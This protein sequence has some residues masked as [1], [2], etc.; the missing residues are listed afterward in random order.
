MMRRLSS[1]N[2]F[3]LDIIRIVAAW[4]VL[5]GHGFS[6][7]HITLLKDQNYFFNIQN[8]GVV[9]LFML[10]GF[11][12]AYSLNVKNKDHRYTIKEYVKQRVVRIYSGYLPALLFIC[13]LDGISF[14]NFRNKYYFAEGFSFRNFLINLF[15]L[16]STP[17]AFIRDGGLFGSGRPLWTLSTEWWIYMSFGTLFLIIANSLKIT[18]KR[19]ILL[20]IFLVTPFANLAGKPDL[21]LLFLLGALVYYIYDK[22]DLK[23]MSILVVLNVIAIAAYGLIFKEAYDKVIYFLFFT[24]LVL[25]MSIG[26]DREMA[27][28]GKI[29]PFMARYTYMLY[30]I[31]YSVF[32]FLLNFGMIP[33]IGFMLGVIL[34]NIIAIGMYVL[35]EKRLFVVLKEII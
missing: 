6:I 13:V 8:M 22:I 23:F 20:L 10:S 11:L 29:I 12:A 17:Y 16:Q 9:I 4:S 24:L 1:R 35:V 21:T 33:V 5:L 7:Y 18:Y 27:H 32:Y 3:Y 15:M 28:E 26:K 34:S 19:L 25:L 2:S 14:L 31:H 30:L